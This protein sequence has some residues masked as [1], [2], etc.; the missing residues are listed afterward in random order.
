M[1]IKKCRPPISHLLTIADHVCMVN[2]IVINFMYAAYDGL[3]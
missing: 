2:I 1:K 3:G